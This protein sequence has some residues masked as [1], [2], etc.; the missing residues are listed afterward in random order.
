MFYSLHSHL[1]CILTFPY[2]TYSIIHSVLSCSFPQVYNWS[3]TNTE[4]PTQQHNHI[5]FCIV[6]VLGNLGICILF[7]AIPL[8]FLGGGGSANASVLKVCLDIF[9]PHV[10]KHEERW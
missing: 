3:C 7:S 4:M 10:S 9:S 1:L 5:C 2:R 6:N 8:L